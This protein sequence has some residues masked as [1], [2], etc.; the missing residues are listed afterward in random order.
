MSNCNFSVSY[1]IA[2]TVPCSPS[3]GSVYIGYYSLFRRY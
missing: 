3:S 2:W 1:G